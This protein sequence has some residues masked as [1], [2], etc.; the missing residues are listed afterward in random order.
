MVLNNDVSTSGPIS[1]EPVPITV[2]EQVTIRYKGFLADNQAKEIY[3]HVGYGPN[4]RW[5][6]IKDIRL[7]HTPAGWEGKTNID[8]TGR[9]NICFRDNNLRWDNNYGHNWSYE[10]HNGSRR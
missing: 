9:F 4:N 10:I 1:V 8:Q 7:Q 6:N 3:A 2:G 5:E